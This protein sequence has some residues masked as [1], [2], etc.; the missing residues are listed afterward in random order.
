M[1]KVLFFL[2]VCNVFVT[3]KSQTDTQSRACII[4]T[5][6]KNSTGELQKNSPNCGNTSLYYNQN[7]HNNPKYTPQLSDDVIYVKLNFIFPT[8]PDGTGNFEQNNPEHTAFLNSLVDM[9]NYRLANL[10]NPVNGCENSTQQISDTKMRVIVNKIWK[11]DPAWDYLITG[12]NP[13]N[14]DPYDHNSIL[15]PGSTYY[16][17]YYDNDPSIPPGINITFANNG[18]IYSEFQNGNY[19]QVPLGWAASEFPSYYQFD[20][21]LRQSWPDIYNGFLHRK[22][23]AVGNPVFGSPTWETVKQWYYSDLGARAMVHELGHNLGLYHH[24]CGSN[25]MSYS[26]GNHDYLSIEDVSLMFQTASITNVRQYFTE[27]SF[28]NTSLNVNSNELWDINFRN[29][30]NVKIDNN[31]SLKTTCKLIMA[32]QSRVIVKN[33]SNFIIEGADV[34]SAND[35]SWNGIKIEG[36]GYCLI[37]PDTKVDNGYF[38]AYTD[39]SV[40]ATSKNIVEKQVMKTEAKMKG[41]IKQAASDSFKIYPNPTGDFINI[42][43]GDEVVSVSIYNASGQRIINLEG[44]AKKI[45]VQS[46]PSGMYLLEIKTKNKVVTEKFIKK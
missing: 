8:K 21:K 40:L 14:N 28:K 41:E 1:K 33:G 19:T 7:G 36:D 37:L 45:D 39:N 22:H 11:V 43:T 23:N 13:A 2:I 44:K 16:Y 15:I 27:N 3:F 20:T 30:S 26:A 31:S 42:Q 6:K 25:L 18:Q 34:R 35:S 46:I 10:G 38:Y 9:I 4:D 32:P 24:D 5:S 29:Y 12:F 17:S